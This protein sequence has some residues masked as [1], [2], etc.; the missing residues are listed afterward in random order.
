MSNAEDNEKNYSNVLMNKFLTVV[1]NQ[2]FLTI[3]LLLKLFAPLNLTSI[4]EYLDK[5]KSN[6]LYLI[7]QLLTEHQLI[8]E[9]ASEDRLKVEKGKRGPKKYYILTKDAKMILNDFFSPFSK[10]SHQ[11][12]ETFE[13]MSK[14]QIQE[15]IFQNLAQTSD[16]LGTLK[17]KARLVSN[18][19][20]SIEKI[21]SKN[22][23][24]LFDEI[25]DYKHQT[26]EIKDEKENKK[27]ISMEEINPNVFANQNENL[28]QKKEE[29][30]K[31]IPVVE[32]N[33]I[34]E[35]IPIYTKDQALEIT[36]LTHK[37]YTDITKFKSE[38]LKEQKE[39]EDDNTIYQHIYLFLGPLNQKA[40]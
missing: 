15:T 4:A 13:N 7:D 32:Y 39:N 10:S 28:N 18:L 33:Q 30:I 34:I 26:D 25:I 40:I 3:L 35:S 23:E 6:T 20:Y 38:R 21:I 2:N 22:Y 36:K 11:Y 14:K 27:I 29:L 19:H 5:G 12:L 1:D 37:F 24:V 17:L 16:E 31:K 8:T 9:V